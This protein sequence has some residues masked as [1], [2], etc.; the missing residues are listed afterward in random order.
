MGNTGAEDPDGDRQSGGQDAV[1]E[2]YDDDD[3]LFT[4]NV[5]TT[6]APETKLFL[7]HLVDIHEEHQTGAELAREK[8]NE[9]K[10]EKGDD[11]A[12]VKDSLTRSGA[13]SKPQLESGD[14]NSG[15]PPVEKRPQPLSEL[16]ID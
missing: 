6:V 13:N 9:M 15:G 14:L 5:Q 11:V 10:R 8:L 1:P 2:R 12:Q 16:G 4:E 3:A 7:E